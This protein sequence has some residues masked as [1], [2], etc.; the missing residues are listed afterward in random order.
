MYHVAVTPAA[1]KPPAPRAVFIAPTERKPGRGLRRGKPS[2]ANGQGAPIRS[3][4]VYHA[5]VRCN[6]PF[7]A[8]RGAAIAVLA[9]PQSRPGDEVAPQPP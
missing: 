6:A 3:G 2:Q 9:E 7:N 4:I 8:D 1:P 5:S